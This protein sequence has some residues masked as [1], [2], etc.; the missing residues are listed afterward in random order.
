MGRPVAWQGD[1]VARLTL[2]WCEARKTSHPTCPP[3]APA[4]DCAQPKSLLSAKSFEPTS[5]VSSLER[6]I[7]ILADELATRLAIDE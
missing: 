5:D 2:Q 1:L 4:F 3:D 6:W 7:G